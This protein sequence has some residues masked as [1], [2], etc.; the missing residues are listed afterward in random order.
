MGL[1]HVEGR[2]IGFVDSDDWIE[3]EMYEK[4]VETIEKHAADIAI[5]AHTL[6]TDNGEHIPSE[7]PLGQSAVWTAHETKVKLLIDYKVG[8][9]LWDKLYKK[10]VF[11]GVSFPTGHLFEDQQV[12]PKVFD[13]ASN[14]CYFNEP[15]YHYIQ[16]NGSI[17]GDKKL[18]TDVEYPRSQP[19]LFRYVEDSNSFS[20]KEHLVLRSCIGANL[21]GGFRN[22]QKKLD[23]KAQEAT[24][25]ILDEFKASGFYH[26][27]QYSLFYKILF[28]LIMKWE[29]KRM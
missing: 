3:P 22:L 20:R 13:N 25:E 21:L 18:S 1:Q 6:E 23:R 11:D 5:C 24:E 7:L 14:V 15:L 16:R 28:K 17:L 9:Y 12:L 8:A 26:Y 2:D 19:K 29:S 10:E 4:L 27:Q